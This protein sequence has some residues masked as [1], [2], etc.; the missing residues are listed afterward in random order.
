[1]KRPIK[2]IIFSTAQLDLY[3]R[4]GIK[5]LH[6]NTYG[7]GQMVNMFD[8]SKAKV[9]TTLPLE[10]N[11]LDLP[12]YWQISSSTFTV[13]INL[14]KLENSLIKGSITIFLFGFLP[15]YWCLLSG[16]Q[17]LFNQLRELNSV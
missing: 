15:M 9:V 17:S 7:E 6:V 2:S 14:K 13:K 10:T 8:L 16:K 1:M 4:N 5:W 11:T 3:D 12:S